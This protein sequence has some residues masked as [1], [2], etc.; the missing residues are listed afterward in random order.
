[1]PSASLAEADTVID[2]GAVNEAPL[3]GAVS[4]TVG[5][6]FGGLLTLI[7]WAADVVVAPLSSRATAVNEYV[8]AATLFQVKL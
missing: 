2:A 3:A 6:W 7:V 5:A 4:E 8:P 1:V